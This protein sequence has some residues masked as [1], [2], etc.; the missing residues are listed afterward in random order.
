MPV[1]KIEMLAGKTKDQKKK[2]IEGITKAITE[3]TGVEPE[4]VWLIIS[5]IQHE[6]WGS[7]GKQKEPPTNKG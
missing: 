2:M 7:G 1:V 6:N 5:E 4:K 3:A